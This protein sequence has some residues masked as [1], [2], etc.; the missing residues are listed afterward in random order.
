MIW[1]RQGSGSGLCELGTWDQREG[2]QT[3][4]QTLGEV[5]MQ[6]NQYLMIV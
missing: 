1:A 6:S 2:K 3:S 4:I 5:H